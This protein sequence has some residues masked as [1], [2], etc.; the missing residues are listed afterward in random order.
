MTGLSTQ[1]RKALLALQAL[2]GPSGT[3]HTVGPQGLAQV[4]ETSPEGAAATAGSLVRR[5]LAERVKVRGKVQYRITAVGRVV[6]GVEA[7]RNTT[8]PP[9]NGGTVTPTKQ[10]KYERT[11][12]AKAQAK[13]L[14]EWEAAG[15]DLAEP[16]VPRPDTTDLDALNAE[17][18]A[19]EAQATKAREAAKAERDALVDEHKDK[20][21]QKR[22]QPAPPA[23]ETEEPTMPKPTPK[24]ASSG[25]RSPGALREQVLAFLQRRGQKADG[26]SPAAIGKALDASS[27]AVGNAL[28]KMTTEGVVRRV[29][30]KPKRYA[31]IAKAERRAS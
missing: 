3:A 24:S 15:G 19:K 30:D 28:E 25:R 16:R 7:S 4:L 6:A 1:Q 10:E 21:Q 17:H 31:V 29:S 12:R 9:P 22:K 8:Q 11:Q 2:V 14:K 5:K 13:A 26:Y 20:Q 27:G 18:E 23:T